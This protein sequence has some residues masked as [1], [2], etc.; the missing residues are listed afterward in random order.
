MGG[1][2]SRLETLKTH[3]KLFEVKS[4][5]IS[6]GRAHTIIMEEIAAEDCYEQLLATV[7]RVKAFFG[8]SKDKQ[9]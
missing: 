1:L 2:A 5:R 9:D 4:K 7:A 6:A 8:Y 3:K